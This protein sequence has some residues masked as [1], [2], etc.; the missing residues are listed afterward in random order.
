MS[1]AEKLRE[2]ATRVVDCNRV[3]RI[4]LALTGEC[5]SRPE[6]CSDC[7]VEW[8]GKLADAIEAEINASKP[9]QLPEGIIWPTFEDGELVKFGDKV[10]GRVVKEFVF[11]PKTWS[12]YETADDEY[13]APYGEPVKRPEPEVLD[14]GG[15]PIKVGDT[16]WYEIAK[17]P[18]FVNCIDPSGSL[19]LTYEMGGW[20]GYACVPPDKV[21]HR[22]PD[23]QEAIDEDCWLDA[24]D[25]CEKYN[26][27]TEWPKHYGKAKCEH[28]LAR[29]RKLLGGE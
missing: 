11:H 19:D 24:K 29:Q 2:F 12:I 4:A 22:K 18:L 13:F 16:V 8:Y 7:T 17:E 10:D 23:T 5:A 1:I 28:L 26:V 9:A 25:Y 21:T 27:K 14:A 15:V 3:D 6:K 20:G